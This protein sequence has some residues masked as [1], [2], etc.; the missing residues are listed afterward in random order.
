MDMNMVQMRKLKD[1]FYYFSYPCVCVRCRH[2]LS[3]V[4]VAEE[5]PERFATIKISDT[6]PVCKITHELTIS[7][8]YNGLN[9]DVVIHGLFNPK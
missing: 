9:F 5:S 6:C 3:W 4:I 8:I 1:G 7:P 2:A